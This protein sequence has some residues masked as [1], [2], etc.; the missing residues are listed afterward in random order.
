METIKNQMD[1]LT[2]LALSI[3]A[4]RD[5]LRIELKTLRDRE[6][7]NLSL[8]TLP[9]PRLNVCDPHLPEWEL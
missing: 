3:K 6:V 4:E 8:P 7:G 1:K 9:I 5:Q 2:E